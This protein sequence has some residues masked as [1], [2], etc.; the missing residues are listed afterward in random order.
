MLTNSQDTYGQMSTTCASNNWSTNGTTT[1]TASITGGCYVPSSTVYYYPWSGYQ[2]A[3]DLTPRLAEL[4]G[5]VKVLREM[6]AALIGG[7]SVRPIAKRA[8]GKK[9]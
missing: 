9:V 5:E 7:G 2:Y 8:R 6:L 3:P 1:T 4:E